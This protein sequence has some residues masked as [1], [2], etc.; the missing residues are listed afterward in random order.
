[1]SYTHKLLP[2]SNLTT[3]KSC[4]KISAQSKF[5]TRF[6]VSEVRKKKTISGQL[7]QL[8]VLLSTKPRMMLSVVQT[9]NMED[10]VTSL[11]IC[12]SEWTIRPKTI[13]LRSAQSTQMIL[14]RNARSMMLQK[15]NG[16]R[17][18]NW[19]SH[20]ISILSVSLIVASSM[21]LEAETHRMNRH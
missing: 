11:L 20:A 14:P 1:M 19:I 15:I 4:P 10:L 9:W 5:K 18:G 3:Q 13:S 8:T 21:W 17:L 16:K 7:W 2:P 6:S 12:T